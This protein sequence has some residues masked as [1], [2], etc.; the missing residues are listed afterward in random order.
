V[1][2]HEGPS[3]GLKR[4]AIL[5][6]YLALVAGFVDS[7]GYLLSGSFTSHVTGNL[8]R[9]STTAAQG[10]PGAAAIA[11]LVLAFF[12]GAVFA[13]LLVESGIFSR[14]PRA[15]GTALL[16]QGGLL[17]L[18]LARGQLAVLAIAMG[19]QNSLV[20]RLSGAVVRTTHLTGVVTDLGI[21]IARWLRW[22]AR[23]AARPSPSTVALLLV[24]AGAFTVGAF[25]GAEAVV[26]RGSEAMAA[27]AVAVTAASL[28]AFVI[29]GRAG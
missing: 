26:R 21:E 13:S 4:N 27:P 10:A 3:R 29:D 18:Y 17:A 23:A 14:R 15:Y 25:S 1:F 2:K 19:M 20:T 6:A 16:L 5:A 11:L 28:Y 7:S 22:G 24:I 12:C 8:A 9:V